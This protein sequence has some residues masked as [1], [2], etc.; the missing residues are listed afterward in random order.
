MDLLKDAIKDT[1]MDMNQSIHK[2]LTLGGSHECEGVPQGVEKGFK[3]LIRANLLSLYFPD[4]QIYL[5]LHLR[6]GSEAT[7]QSKNP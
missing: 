3:V 4:A 1:L 7:Q 6:A 5:M 2:K